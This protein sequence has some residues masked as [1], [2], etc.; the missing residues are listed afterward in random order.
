ML[1]KST[2]RRLQNSS[3]GGGIRQGAGNQRDEQDC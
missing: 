3:L 1:R 2:E